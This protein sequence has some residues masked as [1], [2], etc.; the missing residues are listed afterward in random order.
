MCDLKALFA[1]LRMIQVQR[2]GLHRVSMAIWWFE[3]KITRIIKS[4]RSEKIAHQLKV[5]QVV[6][7]SLWALEES[8]LTEDCLRF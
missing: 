5:F 3:M 1:I 2:D 7:Q 8:A 6:P 4:S